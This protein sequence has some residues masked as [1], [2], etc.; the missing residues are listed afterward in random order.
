MFNIVNYLFL[1]ITIFKTVDLKRQDN[2]SIFFKMKQIITLLI[3]ISVTA[4]VT[5]QVNQ[6]VKINQEAQFPGGDQAMIQYVYKNIK[7]P[8]ETKGRVIIDEMII[9]LDVLPDSSTANITV[10]KKVGY[11]VDEAVVSLI[12]DVKFVPSVQNGTTVKMN[13][14]LNIPVQVRNQ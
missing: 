3:L 2:I 9:S 8:D 6:Q 10:L 11:G 14:M 13:I 5:A 4:V 7:W 12:K 1:G